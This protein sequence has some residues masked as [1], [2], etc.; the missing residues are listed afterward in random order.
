MRT[1]LAS[2]RKGSVRW[3]LREKGCTATTITACNQN[4]QKRHTEDIAI[5]HDFFMVE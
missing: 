2:S 4:L 3:S 1:S 5:K